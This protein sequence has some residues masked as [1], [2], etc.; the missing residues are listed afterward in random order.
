MTF[1]P[2]MSNSTKASTPNSLPTG[3][4]ASG[5]DTMKRLASAVISLPKWEG[6]SKEYS[7]PV[8]LAYSSFHPFLICSDGMR[9][10]KY[11]RTA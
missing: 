8:G 7:F 1:F 11:S 9:E 10:R 4:K 2:L 5:L 3:L 6:S